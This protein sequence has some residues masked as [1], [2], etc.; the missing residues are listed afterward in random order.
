M[1]A[2]AYGQIRARRA[3]ADTTTVRLF[4]QSTVLTAS[5][6]SALVALVTAPF[7]YLV[8]AGAALFWVMGATCVFVG[9]HATFFNAETIRDNDNGDSGFLLETV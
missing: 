2:G 9:G 4:G 7:L 1:V 6:R 3:A 8:G 5:H